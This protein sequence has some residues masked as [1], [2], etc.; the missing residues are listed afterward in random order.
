LEGAAFERTQSKATSSERIHF[1]TND[2]DNR[3]LGRQGARMLSNEEVDAVS[4]AGTLKISHL[5]NGE[6]DVLADF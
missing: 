2:L 6:V 4:G 1:M 3:V 5:P